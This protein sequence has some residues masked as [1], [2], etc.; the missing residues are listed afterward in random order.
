MNLRNSVLL[1]VLLFACSLFFSFAFKYNFGS[2]IGY[3]NAYGD[4]FAYAGRG[5]WYSMSKDPYTKVRSEYPQLDAYFKALPYVILDALGPLDMTDA[6][7]ISNPEQSISLNP[8]NPNR[9]NT[10]YIQ[11]NLFMNYSVVFSLL[12][13]VFLLLS[14]VFLY[15]MRPDRKYLAFLM[16]LPASFYYSYNRFDIMLCFL[17]LLSLY[18]LYKERYR[19]S[20][21]AIALGFFMKWYMI[22]LMPVFVVYYYSRHKKINWS[23]II[24]F[25]LVSVIFVL[26]TIIWS[27]VEGLYVPF[28]FHFARFM[29]QPS[30]SLIIYRSL[31]SIIETFQIMSLELYNQLF[32]G[33]ALRV[34]FLLQFSII[35]LCLTSKIDTFEKVIKWSALSVLVFILFAKINSPHWILWF[36]CLLIMISRDWKYILGII[37]LDLVTYL[38]WPIAFSLY[39]ESYISLNLALC[40]FVA[41]LVILLVFAVHIFSEVIS[42]NYVYNMIRKRYNQKDLIEREN[43]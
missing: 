14:I 2:D 25:C 34:G 11:N 27:G 8:V 9:L 22:I 20:A 1:L 40:V 16:L 7:Q 18:L 12:M 4:R 41:W 3:V 21:L 37:L 39:L 30:M 6:E 26:S 17:T 29:D 32:Y 36:S 35:P 28:E 42:D 19:W 15:R 5:S 24:V 31:Y 23:M 33:Y 13:M 10:P 38:L 43:V